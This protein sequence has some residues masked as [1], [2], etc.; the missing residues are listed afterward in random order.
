MAVGD[1]CTHIQYIISSNDTP[2][3]VIEP[4]GRLMDIWPFL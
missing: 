4:L 1:I 3:I 2:V